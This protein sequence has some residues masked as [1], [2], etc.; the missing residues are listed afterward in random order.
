MHC[1]VP[2]LRPQVHII[3]APQVPSKLRELITDYI[4]LAKTRLMDLKVTCD[5]CLYGPTTLSISLATFL[6]DLQGMFPGAI[7]IWSSTLSMDVT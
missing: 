2:S 1:S 6:L 3:K 5:T 4:S 7:L